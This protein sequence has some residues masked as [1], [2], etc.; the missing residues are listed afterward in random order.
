MTGERVD[1]EAVDA[2]LA[3]ST[4]GPWRWFGN[5]QYR[6]LYLA[7]NHSGRRYVMGFKRWGMGNAQPEFQSESLMRDV[8][9]LVERGEIATKEY[10]PREVLSVS[11]P[12]MLLIERAPELLASMRDEL[13]ALRAQVAALAGEKAADKA[14]LDWIEAQFAD[15]N[16]DCNL[17]F[18]R[19]QYDQELSL[20][21]EGASWSRMTI[22]SSLD[23]ARGGEG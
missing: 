13:R 17:T 2:L 9:E 11:H 18:N 22:R 6:Q 23:A 12:D 10:G 3:K 7:T 16:R 14:R 5:M 1:L 4:P 20:D 8:A 19:F 15:H 21:A